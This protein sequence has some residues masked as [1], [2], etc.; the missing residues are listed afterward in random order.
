MPTDAIE[1]G[2][3]DSVGKLGDL[4][5]LAA[6]LDSG[7]GVLGL[8]ASIEKTAARIP[9]MRTG[10]IKGLPPESNQT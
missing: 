2:G 8:S 3:V 1:A 6:V 9:E 7:S 4:R 5:A 10:L